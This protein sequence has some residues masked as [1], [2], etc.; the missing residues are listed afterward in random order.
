MSRFLVSLCVTVLI[1][2]PCNATVQWFRVVLFVIIHQICLLAY[3]GPDASMT[4]YAPAKTGEYLS[5]VLRFSKVFAWCEKYL[6]DKHTSFH[7]A[8]TYAPI[9]V[10]GRNLFL[11]AH[12]FLRTS[13]SKN[14]SFIGIDNV[15]GQ[16]SEHIFT[17]NGSYYFFI[18]SSYF[19]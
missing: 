1:L 15:R 8:R 4:E 6:K 5:G 3:I 11:E 10:L 14:H 17:P 13:F 7:C 2:H 18:Q 19:D 16:I 12:S 9:F